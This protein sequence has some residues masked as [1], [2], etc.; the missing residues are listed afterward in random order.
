MKAPTSFF[1]PGVFAVLASAGPASA[2]E[3]P[4]TVVVVQELEVV[5]GSRAGVA[6]PATLAVPVDIYGAE[7]I[8]RLGE[9]DL[10]EV[11]GRIAPSFNSTRLSAGDGAALH[12]ATLRGM[13]GDQVLVLVNG[14]RRHGVAFA[15]LLAAAGQGTTGTDLRAIPVHAIERIEVLREGAASQY[16]SDAIAGVINIVLKDDASGVSASTFLGRTS[17]GD[18]LRLFTSANAGVPLGDG[19]FNITMEVARQEVTN[20]AGAAPTCFGPD[21]SYGPCADGGKVIQ[22]QRNGEPDYRGAAFMANAA[23]PVGESAEFYAFGGYSAREAVSDGLYRKADWVPRSVSYVYPDGFFPVEESDLM[24]KSA[25]AGLRGDVGEWS[26]DLSLGFGHGRFAF[27]AENSI[28]PSYAA[29][30]LAMNPGADGASIAANAGPRNTFSGGLNV[31]QWTLNADATRELEVGSTPAFLAVGGA[32]RR[33]SYWM[34]AGDRASWACGPSD[35]PGSFPAAHHQN[36][37]TAYAS[38]GMQGY[39]GYS[40]TSASLS[41]QDRNSVGAYA[42][43]ELRSPS[44]RT[45]GG[46]LRF[47]H[48][49]D[50]GSSLTGKLA[51]RVGLGETGA[52]LRAAVSTGFRAPRLPQRGFNTIGFV[53]GSDGL[54]SAGFLPEGDPIACSDFGACSLDHETSLSFTGGLV[55]SNDAGLLVTADYYRV[56][57]RDAIALTRSLDPSHGLRPAAQ[58]Q[59]RPVDAVAFWTNAIDTRTQGLDVAATWRFRGMDWGAADLSASLHRNSTKITANRNENFIGD[60]QRTLIEDAQPGQRIGVSADIRFAQGLGARF[61]LNRIGSVTTPFIFE[62]NVTIDAAT[63]ADLEVSF[64]LGDRIRVGVGA[65]NLLDRLPNRLPD[66]AVAQLWTMEYPS[67]S[68]YGVAGRLWYVRVNLVGN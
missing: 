39:P 53:G 47:E 29:E 2:Q 36:D 44:G 15:K 32:F 66:D 35:T 8:A 11:L 67:E 42:D 40:P 1:V 61:G 65:N 64:R 43:M 4:D 28:N 19:F 33:D 13:N 17:R 10:A 18:G 16:G 49:T 41:E 62:E 68:P 14:K 57:V 58:F 25:V 3:P 56:A 6:D 9:I 59:G 5:V 22:L 48:Y 45:L 20:R 24:D 30:F 37:G 55:Y 12:V 26:G 31:R 54:V 51:G 50:A 46:A 27:G 60:T 7:E 52:A 63:I 34:E 23:V 21:P 38:C